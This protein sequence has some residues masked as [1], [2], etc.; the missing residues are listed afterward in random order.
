MSDARGS[1][2]L[3]RERCSRE[4]GETEVQRL[5]DALDL[6]GVVVH[7]VLCKGQPRPDLLS[8]RVTVPRDALDNVMNRLLDLKGLRLEKIDIF[9]NGIPD[10][11]SLLAR[12]EFGAA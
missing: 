1:V 9:P 8:G 6:R 12:F 3:L 10:I 4:I 2:R 7:D 11:E 5:F